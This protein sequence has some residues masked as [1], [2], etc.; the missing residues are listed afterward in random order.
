MGKWNTFL[1]RWGRRGL[2]TILSV[3]LT[4]SLFGCDSAEPEAED[5]KVLRV[6]ME[7]NDN[8][9]TNGLIFQ[10]IECMNR[11][12]A[13][14]EGYTVELETFPRDVS[15]RAEM[16]QRIRTELMAGRGPDVLLLRNAYSDYDK[17]NPRA[18][19]L[20]DMELAMQN[21]LF[22]DISEFYDADTALKTEELQSV[23]MEAGMLDGARYVLP[24]RFDIPVMYVEKN[25]FAQTGLSTDIFQMNILELM[26][27]FVS[28]ED[29][30][31]A[32]NFYL[33]WINPQ[34]TMNVFSWLFDYDRGSV[35]V[36]RDEME[37]FLRAYQAYRV[38]LIQATPYE[39]TSY[40]TSVKKYIRDGKYW[41]T[42]TDNFLL[43][44]C[45]QNAVE[46]MAIG[47]MKGAELEVHPVRSMDGSVVADITFYGAV[48][49]GSRNPELAYD[50]LRSF[51][52]EDYQWERNTV[53]NGS[54]WSLATYGW[55]VRTKGSFTEVA[56][57]A[58]E[59]S[60]N[61]YIPQKYAIDFS[62]LTNEDL[63][64]EE[65]PI[66]SARFSIALEHEFWL[67]LWTLVDINTKGPTD[68]DISQLAEEW[69]EKLQVHI[70]EG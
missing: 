4:V 5:S 44:H 33:Q 25:R 50:F 17:L 30:A 18:P 51:L 59:A 61:V 41:T 12:E 39:E 37:T 69:I 70:E 20:D 27:Y 64:I 24:F 9:D 45:L 56:K 16:L 36:T 54:D 55:P 22:Y 67:A 34:F 52:T 68:V 13:E 60:Q 28:M 53:Q 19:L 42:E 15:G 35:A 57:S 1:H 40:T 38:R 47:K 21:G 65:L 43:I 26:D 23:I 7:G 2:C 46:T 62:I 58:Q 29:H 3:F 10:I 31:T 49:A 8:G 14:H 66:D 63:P 48:S 32:I 6:V 11:F